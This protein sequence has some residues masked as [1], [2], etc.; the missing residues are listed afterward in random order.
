MRKFRVGIGKIFDAQ[1]QIGISPEFQ[2]LSSLI[3][4]DHG[5]FQFPPI[6][7][8]NP[9]NGLDVYICMEK[10]RHI[11]NALVI[12][13][14]ESRNRGNQQHEHSYIADNDL[15]MCIRSTLIPNILPPVGKKDLRTGAVLLAC[16]ICNDIGRLMEKGSSKE[17]AKKDIY[18]RENRQ[19]KDKNSN[20]QSHFHHSGN[21]FHFSENEDIFD[22]IKENYIHFF[23]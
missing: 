5:Y 15:L 19:E 7:C 16:R 9:I 22:S 14:N 12:Y 23:T 10:P 17:N 6:I 13:V 21:D 11:T 20:S 1:C 18:R 3:H 2:D 8:E 4:G